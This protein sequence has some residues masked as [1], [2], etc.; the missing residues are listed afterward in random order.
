MSANRS[1]TNEALHYRRCFSLV[2]Q[3]TSRLLS[4]SKTGIYFR[5]RYALHS[6]RL[7]QLVVY[8][9]DIVCLKHFS[10]LEVCAL[11]S[12]FSSCRYSANVKTLGRSEGYRSL[13]IVHAPA[14]KGRLQF[15]MLRLR[16]LAVAFGNSEGRNGQNKR[17]LQ[18]QPSG[19]KRAQLRCQP[20][21]NRVRTANNATQDSA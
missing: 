20:K 18:Y 11:S 8:Y 19:S 7:V 13:K 4:N 9:V 15:F 3:L 2:K 10:D 6:R 1:E 17:T 21:P 5:L 14:V 16:L 12:M